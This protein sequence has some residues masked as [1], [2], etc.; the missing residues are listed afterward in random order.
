MN[1]RN[2]GQYGIDK[3]IIHS[4]RYKRLI[5][6]GV[7]E[8]QSE[9]RRSLEKTVSNKEVGQNRGDN[10]RLGTLEDI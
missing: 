2:D 9:I 10:R 5:D 1:S 4:A 7:L 3:R 6:C 8:I